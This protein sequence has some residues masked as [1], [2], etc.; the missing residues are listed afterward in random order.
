MTTTS[1]GDA[2]TPTVRPVVEAD[3]L[4]VSRIERAVFPQPWPYEAFRRFLDEPG[5][6]VAEV[7]GRVAGYVVADVTPNFGHDVGHVKDIAV[8]PEFQGRG[9]GTTLLERALATLAA[10]GAGS[11]KLEVRASNEEAIRL[12]RRHGFEYRR[13][14]PRYY[15]DGENALVLVRPTD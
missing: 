5:F 14:I 9:I 11:V 12:Y 2:T 10:V 8:H 13:T 6:L 7:G 4:D 1:P 3:L 15:G